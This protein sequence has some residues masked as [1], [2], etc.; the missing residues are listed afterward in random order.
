M[1]DGAIDADGA[2]RA[3]EDI[4]EGRRFH[5]T[6]LPRPFRGALQ[7][8]GDILRKI[9]TP[10][11]DALEPL[12]RS[13]GGRLLLAALVVLAAAATSGLLIRRR[14]RGAVI[15]GPVGPGQS[16]R[17]RA[18]ELDRRADEAERAGD[19][20]RAY[21]YRFRAIVLRCAERGLVDDRPSITTGEL[22]RRL[23]SGSFDDLARRFDEI[24]FGGR[25]ASNDDV[26]AVR[27]SWPAIAREGSAG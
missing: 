13:V 14:S 18:E 7:W 19:L 4:L 8:V 11:G 26:A 23:R 1:P 9:V 25:P 5:D 3:A 12:T 6:Q 10:I 22:R 17:E 20:A 24:V 27:H 15:R 16:P 21:R 2:R